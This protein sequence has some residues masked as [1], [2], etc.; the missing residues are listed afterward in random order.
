LSALWVLGYPEAALADADHA[1]KDAREI[2]QVA[3]L[4]YGLFHASLSHIFCGNY[5]AANADA[6]EL[7]ALA[8]PLSFCPSPTSAATRSRNTSSMV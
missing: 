3:T 8:S 6:D 7:V 5:A 2:G 4:M 1:V